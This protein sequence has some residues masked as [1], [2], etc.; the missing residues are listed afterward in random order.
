MTPTRIIFASLLA[1]A[2]SACGGG[3][4]PEPPS[5][6]APPP[7]GVFGRSPAA[8][9]GLPSVVLLHAPDDT[10]A[11]PPAEAALMDQLGLA[12][13]PTQLIVAAGQTIEFANSES[14]AHN[15]HVTYTESDSTVYLEDMD[16]DTRTE[17]VLDQEGAYDVTCDEHPGMRAFIYV[18]SAPH[19]TFA[20]YDGSFEMPDVPPG[21]YTVEVWSA[22]PELRV[23]RA[24]DVTGG[25]TELDLTTPSP[26]P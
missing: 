2:C 16:P 14:L 22:S 26:S 11:A 23:E 4:A 24:V 1:A 3:D 6:E 25:G 20:E 8:V 9:Q 13:L 19:A 5:E 7:E 18:T 21:T 15:V 12:F 10:P 17:V